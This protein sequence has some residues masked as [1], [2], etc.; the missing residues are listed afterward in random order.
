MPQVA[1]DVAQQSLSKTVA[2]RP[3]QA[4]LF[5]PS[6]YGDAGGASG[7]ILLGQMEMQLREGAAFDAI[8]AVQNCVKI[9][10]ALE[11]DKKKNMF[12]Q[13]G[14]TRARAKITDAE[15][16]R[17]LAISSYNSSRA[18]MIA[19]GL[20]PNNTN[21]PPLSLR[22][23][24]RRSTHLK[25]KVGDSKSSDGRIWTVGVN[26]GRRDAVPPI[27]DLKTTELST[28]ELAPVGTQGSSR[29]SLSFP[30][31]IF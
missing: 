19:L 13:V 22:D 16:R 28:H 15:F 26:G 10:S 11:S 14:T 21:F 8:R 18:A 4:V 5:I 17:D 12:G 30:S 29:K 23:T 3:E 31:V 7:M 9:I 1:N 6:D 20:S 25:R 27:L 24:F 2:D